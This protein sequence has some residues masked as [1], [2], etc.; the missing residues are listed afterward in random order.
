MYLGG[1]L[2]CFHTVAGDGIG[3]LYGRIQAH[4]TSEPPNKSFHP[5]MTHVPP[6]ASLYRAACATLE[7]TVFQ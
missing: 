4:I 6:S 1:H 3:L 2:I 5:V 7:R